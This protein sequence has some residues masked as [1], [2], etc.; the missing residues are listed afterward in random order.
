[1]TYEQ[2]HNIELRKINNEITELQ[3]H[4]DYLYTMNMAKDYLNIDWACYWSWY[5]NSE[6][7]ATY[8]IRHSGIEE[9]KGDKMKI[10][11]VIQVTLEQEEI[12]TLNN[13]QMLLEELCNIM[14]DTHSTT[15]TTIVDDGFENKYQTWTKNELTEMLEFTNKFWEQKL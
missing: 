10:Q 1:M 8:A 14:E 3:R 2:W 6:F 15:L 7:D 13:V 12:D 5:S 9:Q 4:T 11:K